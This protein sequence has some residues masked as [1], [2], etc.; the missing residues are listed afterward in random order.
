MTATISLPETAPVITTR[1]FSSDNSADRHSAITCTVSDDSP[2]QDS[3]NTAE[4]SVPPSLSLGVNEWMQQRLLEREVEHAH[5]MT[6][7]EDQF[8]SLLRSIDS[9]DVTSRQK[10][11][12]A[13]CRRHLDALHVEVSM[14]YIVVFI[15]LN[16]FPRLVVSKYYNPGIYIYNSIIVDHT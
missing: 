3:P 5:A 10:G 1:A 4:E 14:C 2:L 12:K 6:H 15:F 13:S 8:Q 11:V 16:I 7:V 9:D